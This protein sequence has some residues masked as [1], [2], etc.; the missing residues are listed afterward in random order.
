MSVI[1]I[2]QSGYS[3]GGMFDSFQGDGNYFYDKEKA[4]EF[5]RSR[6]GNM[7]S[8]QESKAIHIDGVLHKVIIHEVIKED[9]IR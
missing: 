1:T 5:A 2:F 6:S 8:V 4:T 3:N 9:E 7:F